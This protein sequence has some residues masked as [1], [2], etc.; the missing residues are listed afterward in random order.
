P[1]ELVA[2]ARKVS[3]CDVTR[4]VRDHA[5]QLIRVLGPL[6]QSGVQEEVQ[7][8]GDEGVEPVVPY[9][10]DADV[11]RREAGRLENWCREFADGSFDLRVSDQRHSLSQSRATR[12]QQAAGETSDS[13]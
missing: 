1:R 4:L 8:A 6:N 7:A 9:E 5:D 2:Q 3:A 10:I 13:E 11:L 12:G